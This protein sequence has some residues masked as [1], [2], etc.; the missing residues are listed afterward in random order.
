MDTHDEE[1]IDIENVDEH[2]SE[3]YGYKG[4]QFS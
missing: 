2:G 3:G 1:D 4:A